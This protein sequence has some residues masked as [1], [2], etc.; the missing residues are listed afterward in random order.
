VPPPLTGVAV[1][2]T[3]VPVHTSREGATEIETETGSFAVILTVVVAL[4]IQ[5]LPSVTVMVNTSPF[6]GATAV[7]VCKPALLIVP[8]PVHA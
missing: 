3:F 5:P 6:A 8:G 2:V 7:A 1:N 4:F